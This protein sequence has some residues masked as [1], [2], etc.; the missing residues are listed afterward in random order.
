[1]HFTPLG[2]RLVTGSCG[3]IHP[4][5]SLAKQSP[6]A[7]LHR[8]WLISYSFTLAY[9]CQSLWLPTWLWACFSHSTISLPLRYPLYPRRAPCHESGIR[10]C[11]DL[12]ASPCMGA[13]PQ[14]ENAHKTDLICIQSLE[15]PCQGPHCNLFS[16]LSLPDLITAVAVMM[17]TMQC[18][19]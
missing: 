19:W 8:E 6:G 7:S 18:W 5:S 16:L 17:I 4:S 1:M 10:S 2:K 3:K 12:A 11:L 13:F 14:H 15:S 9:R